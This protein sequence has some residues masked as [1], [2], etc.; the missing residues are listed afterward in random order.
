MI[1]TCSPRQYLSY[2]IVGEN[3][4]GWPKVPSQRGP[5][6]GHPCYTQCALQKR[7]LLILKST[8]VLRLK[9]NK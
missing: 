2:K 5:D 8:F 9:I 4:G 3:F 7:L 1:V 6:F